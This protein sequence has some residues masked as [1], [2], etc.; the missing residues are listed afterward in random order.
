MQ[1]P[2]IGTPVPSHLGNMSCNIRRCARFLGSVVSYCGLISISHC[3]MAAAIAYKRHSMT[4]TTLTVVIAANCPPC[5]L[6]A[7]PDLWIAQVSWRF[8]EQ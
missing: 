1:Q 2:S 5:E 7:P 3:M 6:P 4:G 8:S